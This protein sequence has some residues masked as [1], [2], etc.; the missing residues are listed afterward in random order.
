MKFSEFQNNN[1][2]YILINPDGSAPSKNGK[3]YVTEAPSSGKAK[4]NIFHRLR[5]SSKNNIEWQMINNPDAYTV[6][7]YAEWKDRQEVQHPPLPT[8]KSAPEQQELFNP[9]RWQN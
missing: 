2:A 7:P 1:K 3:H 5:S 6:I 4:S 9:Q 8:H